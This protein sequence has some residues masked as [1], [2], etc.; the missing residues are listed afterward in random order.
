MNGLG[1]FLQDILFTN[2]LLHILMQPI[3]SKSHS[4]VP[5]KLSTEEPG[6]H[7]LNAAF[8]LCVNVDN[9]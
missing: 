8:L 9:P 6:D 2:A 5:I 7:K 3:F 4:G 1:F